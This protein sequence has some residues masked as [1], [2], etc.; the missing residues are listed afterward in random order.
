MI[1]PPRYPHDYPD[2]VL[3]CQEALE[4]RIIAVFDVAQ[5]AGW[6]INEITVA[7]IELAENYDLKAEAIEQTERQ[8]AEMKRQT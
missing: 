1:A 2:R 4:D 6:S 7:L 8:I 5:I 3:D